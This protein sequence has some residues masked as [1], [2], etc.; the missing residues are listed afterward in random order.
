ME[1]AMIAP[2]EE[3]ALFRIAA[4]VPADVEEPLIGAL[5]ETALRG[6]EVVDRRAIALDPSL[7]ALQE[8]WARVAL[9]GEASEVEQLRVSLAGALA[10]LAEAG[11]AP[12][13]LQVVILP[14][15][16]GWRDAWKAYFK[17]SHVTPRIVI[18]PSWEPYVPAPGEKVLDLDPG[19]A[20]GTGGHATTR[21]CLVALDALMELSERPRVLDVGT[22]SGI[23]AIAAAR[24]GAGTVVAVDN[25]P[26]AVLVSRENAAI[27]SV[28]DLVALSTTPIEA[29]EG[30]FD[31]VLANILA[32]TLIALRD[33]IVAR[34]LPGGAIVLS[35]ILVEE[36][37]S[38]VQ[39]YVAAGLRLV[40]E[41][42]E[43]EW[44]ALT[45]TLPQ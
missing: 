11:L 22:G 18:R 43:S 32:P 3:T 41:R 33:A 5:G 40:D 24:L 17:V 42:S 36:G 8:G 44:V 29:V 39:S 45:L 14:V 1:L 6:L 7:E 19:T 15:T 34:L 38:V 12:A 10:W 30:Q 13:G 20:F 9:F 21:L 16:P 23:L 28:D 25:D 2:P 31:I 37:P 4:V 35:G 27:N 26:E